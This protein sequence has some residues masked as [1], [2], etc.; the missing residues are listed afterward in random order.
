MS[1]RRG[2]LKSLTA[3][4]D[5]IQGAWWVSVIPLLVV[6][7]GFHDNDKSDLW[8]A[9]GL[10]AVLALWPAIACLRLRRDRSLNALLGAFDGF[11]LGLLPL[12]FF[13]FWVVIRESPLYTSLLDW[14]WLADVFLIVAF[15]L[16]VGV[17]SVL[18]RR[19]ARTLREA[20]SA[21]RVAE[22]VIESVFIPGRSR[23][24]LG[25]TLSALAGVAATFAVV[26]NRFDS[27]LLLVVA[28]SLHMLWNYLLGGWLVFR[29]SLWRQLGWRRVEIG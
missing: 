19:S 21:G 28:T 20:S 7:V 2:P 14:A 27:W 29:L 23:M 10:A 16:G 9:R 3:F 1:R 25:T 17:G 26:S 4:M 5:Q 24:T 18:G 11:L 22:A 12:F 8:G 6:L 13:A 15:V